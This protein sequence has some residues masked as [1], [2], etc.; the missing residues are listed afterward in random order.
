MRSLYSRPHRGSIYEPASIHDIPQE[1]LEKSLILLFPSVED[2]LSASMACRAWR[3]VAQKLIHSRVSIEYN[4][5]MKRLICGYRLDSLVFGSS[6]FQISNLSLELKRIG[7]EYIPLIAQIVAPS[8]SSLCLN[9]DRSEC[10]ETLE[11]FFSRCRRIRNLRL[12]G[13]RFGNY[14]GE[15]TPIIKERFNRFNQLKLI[16]CSGNVRLFIE[17]T[18]IPYLK[19]F[20]LYSDYTTPEENIDIVDAAVTYYGQSLINLN[21]Y[22]CCVSSANIVKIAECCLML[23]NLIISHMNGDVELS[24][25]RASRLFL[26]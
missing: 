4:N 1:V 14:A 2:L 18:P 6:S 5:I 25:S 7:K 21:L 23:E 8:L 10:Y 24:L 16:D 3:P 15:I 22:G 12:E 20:V 17:S 19:S 9:F 26:A 13:F 11:T